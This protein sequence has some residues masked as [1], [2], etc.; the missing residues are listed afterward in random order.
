MKYVALLR[1]INVGGKNPVK[2][3]ELKACFEGMGF[4]EVA[5][6]LQSGNVLFSTNERRADRLTEKIEKGLS[7]SFNYKSSVVVV[8][9]EQFRS[10]VREAPRGFGTEPTR[11]RYDVIFLKKPLSPHEAINNIS[12][13]EGVD[14]VSKG[15]EVLYTSRLNSKASQSRLP[16]IT[17]TPVYQSIT[18]RNWN[19]TTRL[20]SLIETTPKNE[21]S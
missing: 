11:Y 14:E 7:N 12:V 9:H 21:K 16:R 17:M 18:I 15:K 13:K 10:V 3:S 2:M 6:L 5:T 8:S 19:T 4:K 1:G 20:L